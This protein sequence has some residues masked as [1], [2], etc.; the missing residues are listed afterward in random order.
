M[1]SLLLH[2][3]ELNKRYCILILVVYTTKYK[4]KGGHGND[5][6]GFH[7]SGNGYGYN[8]P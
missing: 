7:Q 3:C 4:T 1:V 6:Q 8:P 2:L 5:T